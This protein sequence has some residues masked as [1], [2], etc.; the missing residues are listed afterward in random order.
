MT[1]GDVVALGLLGG[2][3]G[4]LFVDNFRKHQLAN[5]A[6]QNRGVSHKGH[7]ESDKI[8][9]TYKRE[10]AALPLRANEVTKNVAFWREF[11][12]FARAFCPQ[13]RGVRLSSGWHAI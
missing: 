10:V 2:L 8:S 12:W 9:A 4:G 5:Q 6:G 11:P 1:R 3:D 7:I 13:S